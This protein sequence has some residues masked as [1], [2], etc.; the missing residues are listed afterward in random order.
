MKT[1]PNPAIKIHNFK[2]GKLK[3]LKHGP[4]FSSMQ[5]MGNMTILKPFYNHVWCSLLEQGTIASLGFTNKHVVML[6]ASLWPTRC[7]FLIAQSYQTPTLA[8]LNSKM[9]QEYTFS[10]FNNNN[11][12]QSTILIVMAITISKSNQ[13]SQQYCNWFSKTIRRNLQNKQNH[14]NQRPSLCNYSKRPDHCEKDCRN[15]Q[16]D[17]YNHQIIKPMTYN[18][19]KRQVLLERECWTKQHEVGRRPQVRTSQFQ[20]SP[21][22]SGEERYL[23]NTNLTN[24]TG[25]DLF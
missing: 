3:I 12:N 15:M 17:K 1:N 24:A 19:F 20:Q 2:Y 22:S 10:K 21:P 11:P 23:F 16:R 8:V 25:L 6:L 9:H 4:T 5:Q 7:H 13:Y 18:Y 14:Q